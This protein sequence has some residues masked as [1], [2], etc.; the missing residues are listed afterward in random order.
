[1]V[2]V[3]VVYYGVMKVEFFDFGVDDFVVCMVFGEVYVIVTMK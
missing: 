3:I 2:V 1:M